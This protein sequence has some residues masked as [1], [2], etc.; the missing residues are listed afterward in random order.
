[1]PS[2][3]PSVLLCVLL[4]GIALSDAHVGDSMFSAAVRGVLARPG[5]RHACVLVTHQLQFLPQCDRVCAP[6]DAL[7]FQLPCTRCDAL[8]LWQP[9][10]T[11]HCPTLSC[12]RVRAFWHRW[13]SC[14]LLPST[15]HHAMCSAPITALAPRHA[16]SPAPFPTIVRSS[17]SVR[18][19]LG[20]GGVVG[21]AGVLVV[22]W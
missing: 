3:A 14:S 20:G 5:G 18:A 16:F 19:W 13:R 22:R 4:Y 17:V 8:L 2:L 11:H 15:R 12:A 6:S 21:G 1:M 7:V 9:P 10:R